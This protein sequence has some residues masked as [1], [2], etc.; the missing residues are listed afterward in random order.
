V[1]LAFCRSYG[2]LG[3]LSDPPL[4][5]CIL[6]FNLH[7]LCAGVASDCCGGGLLKE[8]MQLK[9]TIIIQVFEHGIQLNEEFKHSVNG[10]DEAKYRELRDQVEKFD[11][12]QMEPSEKQAA[13]ILSKNSQHRLAESL[14]RVVVSNENSA[15]ETLPDLLGTI[16]GKNPSTIEQA[17][18][19]F[20]RVERKIILNSL[21]FG[22]A[23]VKTDFNATTIADRDGRLHRLSD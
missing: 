15:D 22:W 5:E 20:S 21:E 6:G 2:W 8:N 23:D 12:K 13:K 19:R 17:V 9:R 10:G 1:I 11:E 7:L 18:K 14:L 4:Q 16:F 3:V